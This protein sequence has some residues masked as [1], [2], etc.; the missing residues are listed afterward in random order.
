MGYNNNDRERIIK[1]EKTTTR[2]YLRKNGITVGAR[3]RFS[4]AAKNAIS[5]AVKK[6]VVFTDSKNVK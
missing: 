6:G 5:E 1:M 3:G 2:E 4:A